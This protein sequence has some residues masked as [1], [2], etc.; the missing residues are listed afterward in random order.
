MH[1]QTLY[2]RNEL[3]KAAKIYNVYINNHLIN[4]LYKLDI[5]PEQSLL[6]NI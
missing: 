3:S 6:E 1:I 5:I 2:L 4:A